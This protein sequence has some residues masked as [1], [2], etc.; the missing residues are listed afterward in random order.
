MIGGFDKKGCDND[1]E[2]YEEDEFPLLLGSSIIR[3]EVDTKRE[4]KSLMFYV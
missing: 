1:E 2:S 4:Q 3:A